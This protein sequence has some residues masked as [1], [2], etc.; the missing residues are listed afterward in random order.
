MNEFFVLSPAMFNLF[1][2]C[3]L[4]FYY[5]YVEQIS[6]PNLDENFQT[7]KNI[8]SIASYYLNGVDTDK[9]EAVLSATE[10]EYWNFLKNTEVFNYEIIGVEK[11]LSMKVND[12]WI[13]GRLDAI[14]KDGDKYYILDY[15][16]GGVY[17]DKTFDYQTMVYLLLC[18]KLFLQREE[19]S[20]VYLDLKNKKEVTILF[21]EKLKQEY[22]KRII[23]AYDGMKKVKQ[24]KTVCTEQYCEY[25]K[26]CCVSNY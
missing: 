26:L 24:N 25:S 2:D 20:F 13:G 12:F 21:T 23:S 4:K 3:E 7:G 9:Y 18:D 8:H 15:K 6:V 16:T 19:L 14:V 5:K 11:S 22:L 1:A 10:L 17:K